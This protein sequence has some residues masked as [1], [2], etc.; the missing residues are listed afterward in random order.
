MSLVTRQNFAPTDVSVTAQISTIE[1]AKP[2][3]I[4][5][6]ATGTPVATALRA[7]SDAGNTAPIQI[8]GSNMIPAQ[9]HGLAAFLPKL[10]YFSAPTAMTPNDTPPGPVRDAQQAYVNAMKRLS[11][12]ADVATVLAWDPIMIFVSALRHLGPDPTANQIHD[13]IVHLHGWVGINGV[14]DFSSGD[15]RGIGENGLEMAEWDAKK[16][17]FVRASRP[18]GF[19]LA[20]P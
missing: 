8:S 6:W 3:A 17:D 12:R 7:L 20:G 10:L 11:L 15:Q 1:A 18:R 16:D 19:L 13:Y 9:L 14:Y 4:I 5:V 2:Q